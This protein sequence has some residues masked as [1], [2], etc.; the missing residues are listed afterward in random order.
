MIDNSKVLSISI[1]VCTYNNSE[2]LRQTL[3][4]MDGMRIPH[5][6]DVELCL[7]N[8]NSSDDTEDVCQIYVKKAK[9]PA[10]YFFETQQ[11]LSFARNRGVMEAYGEYVV[12]T[13]DDV[14]VP[15]EWIETYVNNFRDNTVDAVYGKILPEWKDDKPDWFHKAMNPAYALLDYGDDSFQVTERGQEFFGANFAVRKQLILENGGFNSQL[16]RTKGRLF[17]GEETELFYKL[18]DINKK[19]IYDPSIFVYHVIADN[20]KKKEYMKKYYS[21]TAESLI[22]L[23]GTNPGR[24]LFGIPY[25]RIKEFIKFFCKLAPKYLFMVL[26]GKTKEL[27]VLRLQSI[28]NNRMLLIYLKRF[29]S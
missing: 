27:L 19:I 8:N 23:D 6:A 10:R 9:W 14:L 26:S 11:G 18:F 2:S 4:S 29:I 3:N 15:E 13:D 22:F 28:R 7:V 20:R 1:I 21:D 16:G 12:L 17:V 24:Q 25:F 5:D